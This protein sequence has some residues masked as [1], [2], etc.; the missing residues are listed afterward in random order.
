MSDPHDLA[1]FHAEAWQHLGRGV[2]D[3]KSPART[4]VFATTAP[5]GTPQARTVVMRA[6]HRGD[7][8]IEVHTDLKSTKV[9]DLDHNP[10]AALLV[11]LPKANLQIRMTAQVE[12]LTG[13]Q[14]EAAWDRVPPGSRISY[15]TE[16]VPGTPIPDA[17]A[18][19]KS[20]ERTRFA[21]VRCAL[22]DIDL[23]HLGPTH[24]RALYTRSDGW[25]G[26][27]CAP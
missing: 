1:A 11:W 6:A 20:P 7:A 25:R 8:M 14:V 2:A 23:V 16:P 9:R 21:V 12:I 13:T 10:R 22:T 18:Y 19:S 17:F 4:P 3:A 27:W 26:T 5:D 24:R 15:G